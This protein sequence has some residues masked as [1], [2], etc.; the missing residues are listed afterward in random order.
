MQKLDP[1]LV[2]NAPF[3][4]KILKLKITTLLFRPDTIYGTWIAEYATMQWDLV[5]QRQLV[6]Y[7]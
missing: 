1:F 7:R 3:R 2:N 6:R 5:C 4:Q